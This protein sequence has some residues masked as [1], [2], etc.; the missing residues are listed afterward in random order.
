MATTHD[1]TGGNDITGGVAQKH[2]SNETVVYTTYIDASA[3]TMAASDVFQIFK[4]VAGFTPTRFVVN[5]ATAEGGGATLDIGDGSST[6][7]YET[8]AN[9]NSEATTGTMDAYFVY[10]TADTIDIIPN[11][12]LD[13]AKFSVTMFGGY[14]DLS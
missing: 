12:E 2:L 8:D 7:R 4:V 6:A 3:I 9:L 10:T 5:V 14:T 11:A 1:W 13:T